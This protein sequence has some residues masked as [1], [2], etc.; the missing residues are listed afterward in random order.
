MV[1]NMASLATQTRMANNK[2]NLNWLFGFIT[3]GC[4]PLLCFTLHA[5]I[6]IHDSSFSIGEVGK[7]G[8]VGPQG[9]PG[10]P[11][12]KGK[13]LSGVKYV[14]W[15][16]T[17]CSGDATVVYSGKKTLSFYLPSL[18]EECICDYQVC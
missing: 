9:P 5:L 10:P 6:L 16:K 18:V 17:N 12:E 8:G 7:T 1:S 11:G 3:K 14:R 2:S 15:G 13:G 4:T